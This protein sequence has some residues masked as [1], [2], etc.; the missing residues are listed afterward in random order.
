VKRR[1]SPRTLAAAAVALAMS[2]PAGWTN[3]AAVAGHVQNDEPAH[4]P[5]LAPIRSS[6]LWIAESNQALAE[7]G[8][9]VAAA[10]DVNG[11]GYGDVIVGTYKFDNGESDEGRALVY[12]GS[13]AGPSI[14]PSWFAESNQEFAEFG[15]SV[16][17]AGDVNGDGY[18]DV[19]VG[20]WNYDN[21]HADEG[22]AFVFHGSGAGLQTTPAWTGEGDYPGA[23][24]GNAVAAAGDVNGDGYDDVIVG[25]PLH[26]GAVEAGG[27]AFVYLGSPA[28]LGAVA[29]WTAGGLWHYALGWTVSTA[30][31]VNADSFAD[32][33]VGA[34]GY[35]FDANGLALV[36][37]GSAAGLATTPAWSVTRT[38]GVF[39]SAV[40]NAGDVNADGFDDVLVGDPSVDSNRGRAYL[41]IGS[42]DGLLNVPSAI[43]SGTQPGGLFGYSVS[44]AGD[45]DH[46][47]MDDVIIGAPGENDGDPGEGRAHVFTG[48][49]DY[50]SATAVWSGSSDHAGAQ[51]GISAGTAGDVDGDGSSDIIVGAQYDDN[52]QFDEGRAYVFQGPA[53]GA[54]VEEPATGEEGA[55]DLRIMVSPAGSAT[56]IAYRLLARDAVRLAIYDA[57]G[58]CLR[59]LV[60]GVVEAGDHAVVWDRRSTEQK[61][62][63]NGMYLVRLEVGKRS[64][65]AKILLTP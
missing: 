3:G 1:V 47:L 4:Q 18:A 40:A 42:P 11:D 55:P 22:R 54:S 31:D 41:Y 24:Y 28:G 7:L 16:A 61:R 13:P 12:H 8:R 46:D 9:S 39:G 64:R 56:R 62:V 25:A 19:I 60:D 27:R 52:G 17:G 10:G 51:Y 32:V 49:I 43:R 58:R 45:I 26:S 65:T 63:A 21:G 35:S 34:P 15:V 23:Q 33:I 44:T 48:A 6:P 29:A 14:T 37:H 53:L 2:A 20:A 30:G 5:H 59:V 57:A 50:L 38:E 36:Y